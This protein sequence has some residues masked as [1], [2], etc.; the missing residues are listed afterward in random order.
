MDSSNQSICNGISTINT[1][2]VGLCLASL[3]SIRATE[4]QGQGLREG[5]R[6]NLNGLSRHT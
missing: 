1:I 4:G 3:L 2:A 5:V 6:G